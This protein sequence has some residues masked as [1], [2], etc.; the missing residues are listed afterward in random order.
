MLAYQNVATVMLH[1]ME[2]SSSRQNL[3]IHVSG[4]FEST[5]FQILCLEQ[6]HKF[7]CTHLQAVTRGLPITAVPSAVRIELRNNQW[8]VNEV[9][10]LNSRSVLEMTNYLNCQKHVQERADDCNK[11]ECMQ[12][13]DNDED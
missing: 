2:Q 4:L 3:E 13:R 6:E 5:S 10:R 9:I 12:Q 1:L 8:K 11:K 7:T